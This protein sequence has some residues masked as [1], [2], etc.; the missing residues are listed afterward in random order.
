MFLPGVFRAVAL[1]RVLP[2]ETPPEYDFDPVSVT[3]GIVGFAFIAL[4]VLIVIVLCVF[5]VRTLRRINYRAQVQEQIV[6]ELTA[7]GTKPSDS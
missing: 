3:P 1:D 6:Q 2:L 4:L 7:Q 5:F